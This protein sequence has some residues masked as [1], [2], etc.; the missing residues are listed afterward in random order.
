MVQFEKKISKKIHTPRRRGPK[1]EILRI[2]EKIFD[3]HGN[4]RMVIFNHPEHFNHENNVINWL[5]K[6]GKGYSKA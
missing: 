6:I 4:L 5:I 2:F 1:T 3:F